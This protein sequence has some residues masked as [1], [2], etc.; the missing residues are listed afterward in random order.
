MR[1]FF[2]ITAG[3]KGHFLYATCARSAARRIK[4]K[5]FKMKHNVLQEPSTFLMYYVCSH[6]IQW[7]ILLRKLLLFISAVSLL[8]YWFTT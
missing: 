1:I 6:F 7:N 8:K 3:E 4:R 2:V 5:Y